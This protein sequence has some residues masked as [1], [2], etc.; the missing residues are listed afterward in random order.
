MDR[1]PDD[2]FRLVRAPE[3]GIARDTPRPSSGAERR[4]GFGGI[5]AG[6]N[7]G[8]AGSDL[9]PVASGGSYF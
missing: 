4:G 8:S 9:R 5:N 2:D 1:E 6:G 3:F 7:A